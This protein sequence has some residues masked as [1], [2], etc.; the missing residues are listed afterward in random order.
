MYLGFTLYIRLTV[1]RLFP[2][3]IVKNSKYKRFGVVAISLTYIVHNEQNESK[4]QC[5]KPNQRKRTKKKLRN[6]K[7]IS[8]IQK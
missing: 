7:W 1:H 5:N 3:K 4:T 8:M 6:E 2:G